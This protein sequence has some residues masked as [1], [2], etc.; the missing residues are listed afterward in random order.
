MR[1]YSGQFYAGTGLGQ[2]VAG[3]HSRARAGRGG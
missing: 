1:G 2:L 3:R